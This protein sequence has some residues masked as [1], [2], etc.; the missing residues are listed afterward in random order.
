MRKVLPKIFRQSGPVEGNKR[1][2]SQTY[3]AQVD[4]EPYT[5][6]YALVKQTPACFL[7]ACT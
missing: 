2:D 6:S 3:E 7:K 5:V 4:L 1:Y